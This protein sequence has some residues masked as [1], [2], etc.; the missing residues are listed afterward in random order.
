[1]SI[2]TTREVVAEDLH[3]PEITV[4]SAGANSQIQ[5]TKQDC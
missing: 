1:M 2:M 4:A 3:A 5:V